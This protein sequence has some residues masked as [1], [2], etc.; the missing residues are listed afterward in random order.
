VKKEV[1]KELDDLIKIIRNWK[2]CE[3]RISDCDGTDQFVLDDYIEDI[4]RVLMPYVSR[5]R[6]CAHIT[7]EEFIDFISQVREE[8]D[9][10][11]RQLQL[12][13]PE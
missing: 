2:D 11:R 10:M 3:V 13:E 8:V 9:D 5:L 1:R 12:P 6:E 7:H 4:T